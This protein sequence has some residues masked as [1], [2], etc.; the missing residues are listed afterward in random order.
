K[1]E[2]SRRE[3][4]RGKSTIK[5]EGSNMELVIDR[6]FNRTPDVRVMMHEMETAITDASDVR[7][8]HARAWDTRRCYWPG[9][10]ADGR[11]WEAVLRQKV[12]PFDGASDMRTWTVEEVVADEVKILKAA[13]WRATFQATGVEGQDVAWGQRVTQ[14]LRW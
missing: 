1:R 6:E 8:R 11:K 7:N 10:S 12:F 14:L 2:Y 9:Q 4:W 5:R 3:R 13:F